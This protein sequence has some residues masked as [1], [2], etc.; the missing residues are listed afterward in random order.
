VAENGSDLRDRHIGELFAQLGNDT[1]TLVRQ[2]MELAR[3]ELRER[4]DAIRDDLNEAVALARR[5]TS[6]KLD[7]AKA[8]MAYKGRKAGD[9]LRMF[10]VA[11]V[12]ALAALGALTACLVLVLN[13]W[14][15]ADLAALVVA[16]AWALV[17]L[18]AGLRGRDRV[19]EVGG[20]DPSRYV[21]RETIETVKD[22]MKKLGDVDQLKPEHTIETVKED[23]EWAKIRGKSDA[24]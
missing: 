24:R 17:A 13:R 5:E 14:M 9:G 19:H 15:D 7:E 2:E 1:S 12:A 3:A 8:D 22:D 20:F 16:V 10:G 21:P 18:T 6:E 11:G 23:V 4:V